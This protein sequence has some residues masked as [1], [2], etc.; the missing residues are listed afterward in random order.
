[1][2]VISTILCATLVFGFFYGVGLTLS[3]LAKFLLLVAGG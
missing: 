2:K 3:Y 1:M